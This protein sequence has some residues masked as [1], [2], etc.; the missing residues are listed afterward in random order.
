MLDIIES[1]AQQFDGHFTI[2]R[3]SSGYK[4]HF[5]C[6]PNTR[7]AIDAIPFGH[8]LEEALGAAI[9]CQLKPVK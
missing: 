9:A 2:M 6:N 8:T 1:I 4:V 3:F 5:G 7:E